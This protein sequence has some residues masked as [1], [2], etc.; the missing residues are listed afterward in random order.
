MRDELRPR[1]SLECGFRKVSEGENGED[2][3]GQ[4]SNGIYDGGDKCNLFEEMV[5]MPIPI[6]F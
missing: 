3:K 4:T 5:G 6:P 1:Y 2:Q